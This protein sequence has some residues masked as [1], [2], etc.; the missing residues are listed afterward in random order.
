M[1][2]LLFAFISTAL[3][4]CT[5]NAVMTE[6]NPKSEN[7]TTVI[8]SAAIM[9]NFKRQEECWNKHDLECYVES[10]ENTKHVQTISSAGITKG[11]NHILRDYK[12]YFPEERMGNLHFDQIELKRLSEQYYYV[13]GRFN[14]TYKNQDKLI[15]GWFSVLMEKINGNWLMISDHSS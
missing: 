7:M 15:Q 9:S 6:D 1:K 10:Y 5:D 11:Y 8:D 14:L 4:A 2:Q 13:T 12:M 3:F